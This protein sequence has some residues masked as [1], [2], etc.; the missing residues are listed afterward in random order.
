MERFHRPEASVK[1]SSCFEGG[2][3]ILDLQALTE[4]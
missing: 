4:S 2:W 3:G 1:D